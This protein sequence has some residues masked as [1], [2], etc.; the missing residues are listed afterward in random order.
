MFFYINAENNKNKKKGG[1]TNE[2][3]IS[4]LLKTK[5]K[6]TRSSDVEHAVVQNETSEVIRSSGL[7]HAGVLKETLEEK[8]EILGCYVLKF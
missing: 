1:K 3:R 8:K 4:A 2:G 7:M 6:G 5:M